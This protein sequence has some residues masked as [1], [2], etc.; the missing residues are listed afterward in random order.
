MER[1]YWQ[2]PEHIRAGFRRYVEEGVG[3]GRFGEAVFCNCLVEA[4]GAADEINRVRMFDIVK[5][6]YNEAPGECWG[7]PEAVEAW[8]ARGGLKGIMAER[9]GGG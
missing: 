8:R 4:F 6:V 3:L 2:L 9:Q 5:W 1:R 7:S